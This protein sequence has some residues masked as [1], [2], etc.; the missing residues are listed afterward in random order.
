MKILVLLIS[1]FLMPS[2]FGQK[3]M[4]LFLK[5]KGDAQSNIEWNFFLSERSLERRAKKN[6][7]FDERD[8][9]LNSVYLQQLRI[10]GVILNT[11]KWLNAVKYSSELT[12]PELLDKYPFIERVQVVKAFGTS[13]ITKDVLLEKAIDYGTA[14]DQIK[15][16]NLDCLHAEGY[17]GNG[18][19]L[20]V[21]DAGFT[22]MDNVSY[23]DSLYA[24]NRVLDTYDFVSNSTDVYG[25]SGHGTMVSSCIVGEK[26]GADNYIGAAKDV[27]IALYRSEKGDTESII[28]EFDLVLAL[29]RCDSVGV[30]IANISL[31]YIDF[32]DSLDNHVYADFDGETT[33][34]ALGVNAAASKG[35]AVIVS[36]GNSGPD[37]ISTPCDA[38]SAFCVGAVDSLGAYAFFSSV[39][40]SADGQVKPDVVA[41]GFLAYV[42]T[43]SDIVEQANGT[44]FSSP[45]MCGAAACL[46]EA[47]PSS[48]VM[49]IFDAIRESA[50]QYLNPDSLKGYGL[51]DFCLAHGILNGSV[52]ISEKVKNDFELFPN[53]TSDFITVKLMAQKILSVELINELGQRVNI[54]RKIE[55]GEYFRVDLSYVAKGIY[56]LRIDLVDGSL[57][58]KKVLLQD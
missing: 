58:H 56:T 22:N 52:S 40:P 28:E 57:L 27:D 13:N 41:T 49:E 51:P 31:G 32:D 16:L 12:A 42:V 30:D 37:Y 26:H 1:L 38:D 8:Q 50:D 53:P 9:P 18:V 7:T 29:E 47:N 20:A 3:T 33:V 54:P 11:S 39:G 23:F 36:A 46:I 43:P 5:D 44:S 6:I 10:D 15:Q 55:M 2:L 17:T 35:I 48:S 21:I 24:N 19:Y 25:N 45:I 14:K 34:A 4:I